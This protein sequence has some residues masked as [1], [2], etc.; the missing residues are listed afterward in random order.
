MQPTANNVLSTKSIYSKEQLAVELGLH[1]PISNILASLDFDMGF[2]RENEKKNFIVRYIQKYYTVDVNIPENPSNFFEEYPVIDKISPVYVS[3][4]TYGRI[5]FFNIKSFSTEQNINA[6]MKAALKLG[7]IKDLKGKLGFKYRNVLENSEISSKVI[8]GNVE[9]CNNVHTIEKLQA[10]I[11]EGGFN[12]QDAIPISYTLKYLKDN[13]PAKVVSHI[14]HT[15]R[16]CKPTKTEQL[17][18]KLTS[19][20]QLAA[21]G[22]DN[23]D[24]NEIYG[25]ISFQ[26]TDEPIGIIDKLCSVEKHNKHLIF[27]TS[28]KS[29]LKNITR[30]GTDVTQNQFST[31]V[32]YTPNKERFK[33]CVSLWEEDFFRDDIVVN[34]IG[35][36]IDVNEIG[37]NNSNSNQINIGSAKLTFIKK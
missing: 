29:A 8:G 33:I 20:I 11:D 34:N 37:K 25:K 24:D 30:Q 32:T 22:I 6:S 35:V 17:Y 7:G 31:E 1:L 13:T 16:Q 27:N 2:S 10:C 14:N 23:E 3:S 9:H 5:V 18:S 12:F 21:I 4:V 19:V 36:V 28:R 15:T 26:V